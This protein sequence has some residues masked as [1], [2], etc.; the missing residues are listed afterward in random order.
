M[1]MESEFSWFF[2]SVWRGIQAKKEF[3]WIK[4]YLNYFFLSYFHPLYYS[5]NIIQMPSSPLIS[6]SSSSSLLVSLCECW[7]SIFHSL[8]FKRSMVHSECEE[9][10]LKFTFDYTRFLSSIFCSMNSQFIFIF[11]N[12]QMQ[13]KK[14]TTNWKLN[15]TMDDKNC[16]DCGRKKN[17]MVNLLI[18]DDWC[19]QLIKMVHR[20]R[21]VDEIY[22][23]FFFFSLSFKKIS[24]LFSV[25]IRSESDLME[26]ENSDKTSK[27]KKKQKNPFYVRK[28]HLHDDDKID[29]I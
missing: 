10:K 23:F 6:S 29:L 28:N 18:D 21:I 5:L 16:G 7:C 2:F 27:K 25:A 19:W 9:K 24:F 22:F 4:Y 1:L 20:L 13:K 26:I 12:L 15:C 3:H 8:Q 14:K 11:V 17:W